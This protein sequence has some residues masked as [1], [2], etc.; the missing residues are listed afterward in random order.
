MT[1][2]SLRFEDVC[3]CAVITLFLKNKRNL[4]QAYLLLHVSEEWCQES[5]ETKVKENRN[6]ACKG[7]EYV[8]M[9]NG[10]GGNKKARTSDFCSFTTYL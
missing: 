6:E 2:N 3:Q 10:N 7:N 4:W 5:R 1:K 8:L 9:T